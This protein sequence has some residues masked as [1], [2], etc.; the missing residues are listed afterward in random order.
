MGEGAVDDDTETRTRLLEIGK[1]EETPNARVPQG[2][3]DASVGIGM[4]WMGGW[5]GG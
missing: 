5:L 3:R 4:G 1:N 2:G